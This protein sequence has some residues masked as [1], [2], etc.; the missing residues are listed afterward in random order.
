[1]KYLNRIVAPKL[2]L[3]L[4][5][6]LFLN[7]L[8]GAAVTQNFQAESK[9]FHPELFIRTEH[10]GFSV[11]VDGDWCMVGVPNAQIPPPFPPLYPAGAVHA[12]KR[13][14]SGWVLEQVIRAPVP[15]VSGRFG[16]Q[17]VVKDGTLIVGEPLYGDINGLPPGRINIFELNNGQW[18]YV[19]E[20]RAVSSHGSPFVGHTDFGRDFDF[21]GER[22]VVGQFLERDLPT[23]VDRRGAVYS[24][25]RNAN[26]NWVQAQR[27]QAPP[28]STFPFLFWH[29]FGKPVRVKGDLMLVGASDAVFVYRRIAGVWN[30][31][32]QLFLLLPG[33]E[34]AFGRALAIDGDQVA[35][36]AVS[37]NSSGFNP[38]HDRVVIFEHVGGGSWIE[39][40]VVYAPGPGQDI[41]DLP[42][43]GSGLDMH[44]DWL[45]VGAEGGRA[46]PVWNIGRCH[47]FKRDSN[48]QWNEAAQMRH[49][50]SDSGGP[51]NGARLGSKVAADWEQGYLAAITPA[52]VDGNAA[53]TE[54]VFGGAYIFDLERGESFCEPTANTTGKLGAL[55]VT[56][57]PLVSDGNLTLHAFEL[58]VGEFGLFLYGRE[59]AELSLFTG[60]QLCLAGGPI[61]RLFPA[62]RVGEGGDFFHHMDLQAPHN[63]QRLLPETTW[64]FQ[65]WHRDMVSGVSTTNTTRAVRLT[66]Q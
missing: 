44:G 63:L 4:G 59:S 49:S 38:I 23:T 3:A 21:D 15:T 7:G 37:T 16:E 2:A 56:G 9:R 11:S 27:I 39:T 19:Q 46:E 51:F 6:L 55:S 28:V 42:R 64:V 25:E 35:V 65:V 57:S 31:E 36:S 53:G 40:A 45:W 48:Q 58:P 33:R 1:M 24:Y 32:T 52:F 43:F 34:Y 30:L 12:Y 60:G 26:G 50:D 22:V 18:Q 13:T 14:S 17:V 20:L 10:F 8:V 41:S 66:L 29:D 62:L 61:T 47:L 5:V 54:A